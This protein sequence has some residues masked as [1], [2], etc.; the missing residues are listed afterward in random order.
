MKVKI[1]G[2][3]GG[4]VWLNSFYVIKMLFLIMFEY[5]CLTSKIKIEAI[6]ASHQTFFQIV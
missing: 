1:K 4:G 6:E 2:G 5:F 3:G